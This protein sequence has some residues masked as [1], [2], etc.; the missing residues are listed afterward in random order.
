MN[1]FKQPTRI[2]PAVNSKDT[3]SLTNTLPSNGNHT[4]TQEQTPCSYVAIGAVRWYCGCVSCLQWLLVLL[5]SLLGGVAAGLICSS[6]HSQH[7]MEDL[8]LLE[9]YL[10]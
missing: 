1:G 3:P 6:C 7:F 10:Q 2:N 5:D 9:V 4:P 8:W